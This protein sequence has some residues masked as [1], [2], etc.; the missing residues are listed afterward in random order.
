MLHYAKPADWNCSPQTVSQ[1]TS[2]EIPLT[3][4]GTKHSHKTYLIVTLIRIISDVF[5]L[6]FFSLEPENPV[7]TQ[8]TLCALVYWLLEFPHIC[9]WSIRK[10]GALFCVWGF[11]YPFRISALFYRDSSGSDLLQNI[12]VPTC[13]LSFVYE[14]W[15]AFLNPW[16]TMLKD[17]LRDPFTFPKFDENYDDS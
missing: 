13:M 2:V 15:R 12:C 4:Y 10:L 8:C 9:C 1:I 5:I 14:L 7:L 16:M 17:I 6:G 3:P 11:R